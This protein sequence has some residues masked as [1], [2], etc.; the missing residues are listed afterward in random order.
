MLVT[1]KDGKQV[2]YT[3]NDG[4]YHLGWFIKIN[5]TLDNQG[6]LASYENLII[7]DKLGNP[8]DNPTHEYIMVNNMPA[9]ALYEYTGTDA[10]AD[11]NNGT[12][13][14]EDKSIIYT[15]RNEFTRGGVIYDENSING[16]PLRDFMTIAPDGHS[17]YFNLSAIFGTIDKPF[18]LDVYTR[19]TP[20]YSLP[21]YDLN[22]DTGS[23]YAKS[24]YLRENIKN[25]VFVDG[26][27]KDGVYIHIPKIIHGAQGVGENYGRLKLNKVSDTQNPPTIIT[28]DNPTFDLYKQSNTNEWIKLYE[29]TLTN[30]TFTTSNLDYGNYRLIETKAPEGHII[31]QNPHGF[32]LDLSSLNAEKVFT[33]NYLN[34]KSPKIVPTDPDNTDKETTPIKENKETGQNASEYRLPKTGNNILLTGLVLILSRSLLVKTYRKFNN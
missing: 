6:N 7:E 34:A 10:A 13:Y 2:F 17:V 29:I 27:F 8:E 31:D 3:D 16:H 14:N 26:T 33:Y 25:E 28:T 22:G 15:N 32:S 21:K 12:A 23:E 24:E 18:R 4:A 5:H 19:T 20:E 1:I 9:F 11:L 30:G